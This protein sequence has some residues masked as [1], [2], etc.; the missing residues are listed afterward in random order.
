GD[1]L[2]ARGRQRADRFDLRHQQVL[3]SLPIGQTLRAQA[4]D[5]YSGERRTA[6]VR[7]APYLR[8]RRRRASRGERDGDDRPPGEFIAGLHPVL[9]EIANPRA[10]DWS[11]LNAA[12]YKH[13]GCACR[14][15]AAQ[16]DGKRL[17]PSSGGGR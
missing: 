12:L 5:E 6:I 3:E 2:I 9:R 7:V 14:C 17:A 15:A 16:S 11:N 4:D 10:A 13:G 1:V 8:L